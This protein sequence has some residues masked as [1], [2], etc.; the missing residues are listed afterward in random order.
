MFRLRHHVLIFALA[1]VSLLWGARPASA[2][3]V[4]VTTTP[5]LAA[6]ARQVGGSS[7]EVSALA[8]PTQDP[9]FVDARPNLALLLNKA[10]LLVIQGLDLEVGWLPVLQAGARNP[11][12]QTGGDGLLDASTFITVME[13]PVGQVS[14][15]QGDV[16]PGGNPHYLEEPKNGAKVGRGLAARLG[17][18]DP[19]NAAAYEQRAAELE[20]EAN[21]L[22]ARL[23]AKA[24]GIDA[25]KRKVVVYH[26]S[27][28]YLESWLG[29]QEVGAVEPKPGIPPDPAHVA[30]LLVLMRQQGVKAILS[31]GYYPQTT[32]KLLAEKTGAELC[33]LSGGAAGSEKYLDH[34]TEIAE[35]TLA[36]L[37]R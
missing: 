2:A 36:A 11:K 25:S 16:H 27:W 28:I 4:V 22:A 33:V 34:I 20:K 23:A 10:D 13:A 31:E 7:V 24:A 32:T 5:D 1:L 8:L 3:V 14:R 30:Q 35:K 17:K 9:H 21:A 18:I 15:A 19:A 12:I 6:I 26:R 37:S 29:L